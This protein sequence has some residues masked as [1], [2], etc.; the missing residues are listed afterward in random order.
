M[1]PDN[2]LIYSHRLSNK[3]TS[4]KNENIHFKLLIKG[5]QE[6]PKTI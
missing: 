2:V 6:T 5:V 4:A 3:I 1:W